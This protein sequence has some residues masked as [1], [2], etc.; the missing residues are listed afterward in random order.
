MPGGPWRHRIGPFMSPRIFC[1]AR[2]S[3]MRFFT[4]SRPQ[5]SSSSI[6]RACA[7]LKRSLELL[8]QGKD[9]ISSRYVWMFVYS[10]CW[11]LMLFRRFSSRFAIFCAFSGSPASASFSPRRFA[12]SASS[13]S[14]APPPTPHPSSSPSS[15]LLS[16]L[17]RTRCKSFCTS[18]I[19]RC[20]TTWR[21]SI[22]RDLWRL[23]LISPETRLASASRCRRSRTISRRSRRSSVSR[24]CC[25]SS[26]E[27]CG[28]APPTTPARAAGDS[29]HRMRR[30]AVLLPSWPPCMKAVI[31]SCTLLTSARTDTSVSTSTGSR[32]RATVARRTGAVWV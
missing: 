29:G 19:C 21:S 18:W 5:W 11:G 4:P 17:L 25:R 28:S 2:N 16:T 8:F 13:S 10:A 14:S 32:S 9:P 6:A 12:S 26:T 20:S 22:S 1:T 27:S 23:L 24:I 7:R 3:S 15:P 31:L 30:A